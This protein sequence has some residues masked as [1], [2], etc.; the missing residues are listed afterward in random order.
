MPALMLLS[1]LYVGRQYDLNRIRL[2]NRLE[3]ERVEAN[4]LR[5]IDQARSRLFANVSHEF[6]TPLTLTLGPLDDLRAGIHGP[7]TPAMADHVDLARRNA[8]RVA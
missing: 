1:L 8:G 4:Q 3:I 7:L 5:E 2:E 6:R